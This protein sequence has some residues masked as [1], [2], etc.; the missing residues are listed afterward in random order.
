MLYCIL[1]RNHAFENSLIS[2]KT[3]KVLNTFSTRIQHKLWQRQPLT[4][5][6]MAIVFSGRFV[7]IRLHHP[8]FH[9]IVFALFSRSLTNRFHAV[10]CECL[11]YIII[12]YKRVLI[13]SEM[14]TA[15]FLRVRVRH[16]VA[17][18]GEIR[19]VTSIIH[20]FIVWNR[21]KW[22]RIMSLLR[23]TIHQNLLHLHNV[24]MQGMFWKYKKNSI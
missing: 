7:Y 24:I 17:R 3:R 21:N 14:R 20:K 8:I 9:L 19:K 12:V 2:E 10:V 22:F 5:L 1:Y 13:I 18:Q 15:R 23:L 6:F 11:L 4:K 16:W